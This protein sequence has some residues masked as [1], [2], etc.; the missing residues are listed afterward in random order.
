[1]SAIFASDT[2]P[3]SMVQVAPEPETVISPLSPSEMPPPPAALSVV[4]DMLRFVPKVMA[5]TSPV[6]PRPRS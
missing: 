6:A 1:M 4:P 5:A 3:A 2:A